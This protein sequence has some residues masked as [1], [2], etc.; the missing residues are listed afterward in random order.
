MWGKRQERRGERLRLRVGGVFSDNA[1]VLNWEFLPHQNTALDDRTC[2]PMP[3][4]L[5][6]SWGGGRRCLIS[7]G[8]LYKDDFIGTMHSPSRRPGLHCR[9]ALQI[10]IVVLLA[11][12]GSHVHALQYMPYTACVVLLD[13]IRL[14]KHL[15]DLQC[16][17]TLRRLHCTVASIRRLRRLQG[18]LKIEKTHRPRVLQ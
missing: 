18:L 2:T 10:T 8:P 4:A 3:R 6:W 5:R 11:R 15:T 14:T 17:S 12:S 1:F 7:E 16:S 9:N 13:F